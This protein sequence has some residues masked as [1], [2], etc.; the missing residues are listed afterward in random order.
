MILGKN[1]RVA[2]CQEQWAM[3]SYSFLYNTYI[4]YIPINETITGALTKMNIK[5]WK[6]VICQHNT[7]ENNSWYKKRDEIYSVQ[8]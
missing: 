2:I 1:F 5:T 3:S 4:L 8:L 7:D 6:S